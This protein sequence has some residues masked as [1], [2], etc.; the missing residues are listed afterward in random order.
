MLSDFENIHLN[1]E[2][3]VPNREKAELTKTFET[4]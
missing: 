2:V 4:I 3:K 1:F